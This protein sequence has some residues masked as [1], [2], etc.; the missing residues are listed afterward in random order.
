MGVGLLLFNGR[1]A[2]QAG[3]E[4]K[5]GEVAPA[6]F[7]GLMMMMMKGGLDNTLAASKGYKWTCMK[8]CYWMMQ[9]LDLWI[10]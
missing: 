9:G 6:I 4:L 1:G 8:V 10:W 3:K 2:N 7:C 5:V